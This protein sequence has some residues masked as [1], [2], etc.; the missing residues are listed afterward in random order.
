MKN[1]SKE[2]GN[3]KKWYFKLLKHPS[4]GGKEKTWK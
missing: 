4:H 1:N 2:K 3:M